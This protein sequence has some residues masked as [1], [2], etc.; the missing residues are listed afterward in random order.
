MSVGKLS[1]EAAPAVLEEGN[2]P[3][4]DT[5]LSSDWEASLRASQETNDRWA[6]ESSVQEGSFIDSTSTL[7]QPITQV[8][9]DKD[10]SH[11]KGFHNAEVS[12]DIRDLEV[13]GQLPDWL[14]GEH[15]TIGPGTVDVKF[16]RKAEVDGQLQSVTA[17][18]RFNHWFDSLPLVNR[19]D[20][21]AKRN[22]ISH[23]QRLTSY[24]MEEK[25]RDHH[26]FTPRHPATF[27]KT[28]SH[29][30]VLSKFL[31]PS[32][33]VKPDGEPCGVHIVTEIPGLRGRLYCRNYANHLQ[34]LDPTDLKPI[35]LQTFEE[36]N[37][38]FKGPIA[39]PEGRVDS[40]TGEYINVTMD[41]GYQSTQYTFMSLSEEYPQGRVIATLNA[42]TAFVNTF[43]LTPNYIILPLF[44]VIANSSK[45][46]WNASILDSHQFDKSQPTRFYVISRARQQVVATYQAR[47]CFA[48]VNAFEV[49]DSINLDMI[50]YQDDTI[51][52]QLTRPQLRQ[53]GTMFPERLASSQVCRFTL[54]N[55]TAAGS[56]YLIYGQPVAS[57]SSR[58]SSLLLKSTKSSWEWMPVAHEE[59]RVPPSLELPSIHPLRSGSSYSFMYGVGFSAN[60]ALLDGTIWD[61]IIKTNM[62]TRSIVGTWYQA[63]CYPS[64]PVFVP[65]PDAIGEDD[66]VLISIVLDSARASSFVLVLDAISLQPLARADLGLVVPLS[67]GCGATRLVRHY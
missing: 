53:L 36:I 23:R 27:F 56:Q 50:V 19:F 3:A 31:T 51:L 4:G 41:V 28:D 35:K 37:P 34:E 60:S 67:F 39:C 52:R 5:L 33:A 10:T 17:F 7:N 29:Q 58:L 49:G 59:A 22:T 47:A 42:P 48:Q 61:S 32:R 13:V 26:G 16:S 12:H 9:L 11:H 18:F 54:G 66:G 64:Q 21:N 45:L 46:N 30:T 6:D 65:R 44:P 55:L 2:W 63:G 24:R 20:F 25:I 40:T 1:S 62:E 43:C 8:V 57:L 38:A 14:T 15:Y